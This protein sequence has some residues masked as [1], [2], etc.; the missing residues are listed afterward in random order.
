MSNSTGALVTVAPEP[1]PPCAWYQYLSRR[2]VRAKAPRVKPQRLPQ[3][4]QMAAESWKG[5]WKRALHSQSPPGICRWWHCHNAESYS[6]QLLGR[7]LDPVRYS[8]Q[9]QWPALRIPEAFNL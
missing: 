3:M 9:L 1:E 6:Q 8:T 5:P 7:F 2:F 4:M